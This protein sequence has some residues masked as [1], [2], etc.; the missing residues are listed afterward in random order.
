[1]RSERPSR[2]IFSRAHVPALA[3]GEQREQ[4]VVAAGVAGAVAPA[5]EHVRE[6]VDRVGGVVTGDRRDEKAPDEHLPAG[7]AELRLGAL[8]QCAEAEHAEREQHGHEDVETV[9]PAQFGELQEVAAAAR[10]GAGAA[11]DTFSL[12]RRPLAVAALRPYRT[13]R[14]P[15]Q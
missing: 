8:E 9:Q 11:A 5:A 6:R 4:P 3:E 10:Q 13:G 7:G 14:L 2:A 12:H 1:M 15:D